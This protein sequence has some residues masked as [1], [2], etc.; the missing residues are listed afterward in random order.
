MTRRNIELMLLL[1]ASPIVIVLF[2]M[3]VVTGGQELS[4]N[5][6]GV[7]LGIFAAFLVAH[8]AVRLLAPAA[9]PAILPISFALSGIG[10][11]FVTR[12][13]PVHRHRGHDCHPR[14]RAQL[15]QARQ[16]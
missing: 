5:T 11:A 16:L 4:F 7:P 14:R 15:G 2:A 12:I 6:L 8:I 13:V 9:D 1:I 10:I 3:M